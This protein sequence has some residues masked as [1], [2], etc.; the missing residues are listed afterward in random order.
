MLASG[1]G[2]L[3]IQ[4]DNF[5]ETELGVF[6]RLEE[7]VKAVEVASLLLQAYVT[8]GYMWREH[9]QAAHTHI[10]PDVRLR[11]ACGR[12][13]AQ[14]QKVAGKEFQLWLSCDCRHDDLKEEET[15]EAQWRG[16][17][18][19]TILVHLLKKETIFD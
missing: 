11:A 14:E 6:R 13:L 17:W 15:A 4:T 10:D 3:V 18:G 5:G 19:L 12:L 8:S 9:S 1:F 2:S 7:V 16:A